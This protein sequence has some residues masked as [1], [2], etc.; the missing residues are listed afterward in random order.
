MVSSFKT[1]KNKIRES[2]FDIAIHSISLVLLV[3]MVIL[4]LVPVLNY[5]SLAFNDSMYNSRITIFP[6]KWSFNSFKYILSGTYNGFWRSFYN[7]VVITLVV[8]I[9]SNLVEALVAYPL[10]K[11]DCPFRGFLLM[12]F[13]IT[14]LF[15]AGVVPIY[16]LMKDLNL[17][18]NIWSIILCSI[19]NVANLLFFKTF[20]E[21]LPQEIEEA[22]IIDGA[23]SLQLFFRIIVPMALPVFGSCCFFSIV[24]MWNGYGGA[25]IFIKSSAVEQMPLAYFL[26][27]KMANTDSQSMYDAFLRDNRANIEAASMLISIIPIF[28]IYPYVIKYIK[29]GATLGSVKG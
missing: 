28:C 13:I 1:N 4:V 24:G 8:T 19:S 9:V 20:F 21:G 14:M 22:A 15:S 18:D 10:S 16:L 17:L 2:A 12:Y 7:S 29:S 23:S 27:I 5:F 25:L 26:Y 3:G 6:Y 11:K